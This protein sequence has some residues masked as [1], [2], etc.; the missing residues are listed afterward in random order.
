MVKLTNE[1]KT[2]IIQDIENGSS[3]GYLMKQYKL[4]RSTV[5]RIKN[6]L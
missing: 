2:Q 4:S 1:L 3:T 5:Q 6:E